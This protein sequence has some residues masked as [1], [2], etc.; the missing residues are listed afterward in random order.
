M[1]LAYH[2]ARLPARSRRGGIPS[3][4]ATYRGTLHYPAKI[5][6][7]A[8]APAHR[9]PIRPKYLA[10]CT[11]IALPDPG[12]PSPS[13]ARTPAS[14]PGGIVSATIWVAD[15]VLVTRSRL[16]GPARRSTQASSLSCE[17]RRRQL[18]ECNA[19]SA[20]RAKRLRGC[21]CQRRRIADGAPLP[22]AAVI[23]QPGV[24]V[25]DRMSRLERLTCAEYAAAQARAVVPESYP[26]QRVAPAGPE[27]QARNRRIRCLSSIEVSRRIPGPPDIRPMTTGWHAKDTAWRSLSE[28]RRAVRPC[29]GCHTDLPD[30][31]G[32]SERWSS[33]RRALASVD[34]T[35]SRHPRS[36]R[37]LEPARRLELDR[38]VTIRRSQYASSV[39][40]Q[41]SNSPPSLIVRPAT[42]AACGVSN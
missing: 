25:G 18:E 12:R 8:G 4:L 42:G 36:R 29:P 7:G 1:W 40:V 23:S 5:V 20:G 32:P 21:H 9:R 33:V 30:P 15:R 24:R 22:V 13:I 6:T 17:P 26:R 10:G 35:F 34:A 37:R 16:I 19:R 31:S 39:A 41:S 14:D 11:H 2:R 38:G 28:V 3:G 27:E